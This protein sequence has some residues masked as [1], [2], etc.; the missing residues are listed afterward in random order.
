M[1]T[2]PTTRRRWFQFRLASV[3]IAVGI[4]AFGTHWFVC[5]RRAATARA[6]ARSVIDQYE[7]ALVLESDVVL[8]LYQLLDAELAVPSSDRRAAHEA[9][10][11]RLGELRLRAENMFPGS[12]VTR[13]IVVF[14]SHYE[15]AKQRLAHA[16]GEAYADSVDREF[17]FPYRDQFNGHPAAERGM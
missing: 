7:S 14:T 1:E 3:L 8:A 12:G 5:H 16:A 11:R 2:Q 9:H 17:D 10:M 13:P 6:H 15:L 4:T